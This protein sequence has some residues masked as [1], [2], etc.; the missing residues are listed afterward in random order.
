VGFFQPHELRILELLAAG[1]STKEIAATLE[2][3]EEA[4]RAVEKLIEDTVHDYRG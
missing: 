3:S 2:L 1:Y 4:V